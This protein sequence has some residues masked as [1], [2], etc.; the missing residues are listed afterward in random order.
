MSFEARLYIQGVGVY[1]PHA[2]NRELLVLFPNQER[3]HQRGL[4]DPDGKPFCRHYAAVQFDARYLTNGNGASLAAGLPAPWTT[5]DI[6]GSWVG[7][8]T[9]AQ[10][11]VEFTLPTDGVVPG[12]PRL[13]ELLEPLSQVDASLDPQAWPG[14]GASTAMADLLAAGLFVD[15]GVL[16]P[17]SEYEG[18]FRMGASHEDYRYASVL[19]VELGQVDSFALRFRRFDSQEVRELPLRSPWD[20]LEVWIRHFCD[21]SRPDPDHDLPEAGEADV[22]FA[23]NYAL[24][25]QLD[26]LLEEL[27]LA[28]LP[29]P[30]VSPSWVRGGP[31]GLEPRKCMGGSSAPY[32]FNRPFGPA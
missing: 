17:Y 7:F 3:A 9:E 24:L 18:L 12:V 28:N 32:Q 27:G 15:A 25:A 11:S 29:V 5:I 16:S 23:L 31:I 2:K 22:D 8:R 10:Q 26:N 21:L 19:K 4:L 6:T 13:S 14:Q 30:A 1:V 20:E